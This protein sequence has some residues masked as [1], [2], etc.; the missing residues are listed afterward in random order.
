MAQLFQLVSN[1]EMEAGEPVNYVGVHPLRWH[2]H[3]EQPDAGFRPFEGVPPLS[4]DVLTMVMHHVEDRGYTRSL[5]QGSHFNDADFATGALAALEALGFSRINWPS[6][7]TLGL[8]FTD[9]S[10]FR[11]PHLGVDP[12]DRL[13]EGEQVLYI[14][15]HAEGDPKHDDVEE[16]FVMADKGETAFVRYF[17]RRSVSAAGGLRTVA[18]SEST[19]KAMLMRYVHHSQGEIDALVRQIKAD[20][21]VMYGRPYSG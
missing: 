16:G 1:E 4:E 2:E 12:L 11:K 17:F 14:P 19:P 15:T 9:K 21:E 18:N 3:P 20:W 8:M 7:W 6:S 13:E 10:P 5:Y